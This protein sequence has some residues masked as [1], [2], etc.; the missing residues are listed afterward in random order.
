MSTVPNISPR[1]IKILWHSS[2]S[3]LMVRLLVLKILVSVSSTLKDWIILN[4]SGIPATELVEWNKAILPAAS[5][6]DSGRCANKNMWRHGSCHMLQ[7]Q[8]A[9]FT[10]TK[11]CVCC[12]CESCLCGN[13][14]VQNPVDAS[15]LHWFPSQAG[16]S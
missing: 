6:L 3:L 9:F 2:C 5:F 7:Q 16:L 4:H 14:P 8:Q 1:P 13:H 15:N 11:C 12:C 10:A